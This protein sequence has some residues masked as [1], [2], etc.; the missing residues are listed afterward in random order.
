MKLPFKKDR[1]PD[2]AHAAQLDDTSRVQAATYARTGDA[3]ADVGSRLNA[4]A[5]E[6]HRRGVDVDKLPADVLRK[7]DWNG[8]KAHMRESYGG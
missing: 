6:A 8:I 2:A 3:R 7:H 1:Q 5:A 4:L